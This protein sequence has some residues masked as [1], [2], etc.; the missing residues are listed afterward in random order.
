MYRQSNSPSIFSGILR[1]QVTNYFGGDISLVKRQT[2]GGIRN[3]MEGLVE[4]N[5]TK[6]EELQ[7]VNLAPRKLI[8]LYLVS[9]I[10]HIATDSTNISIPVSR[11][12]LL[13]RWILV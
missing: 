12:R 6:A 2:N 1:E 13:T 8:E 7:I 9:S 4:Y 11:H 5:L 3:L 10:L